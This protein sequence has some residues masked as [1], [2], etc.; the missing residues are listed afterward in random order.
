M[1]VGDMNAKVVRLGAAEASVS[2]LMGLDVGRTDNGDGFL[3]LFAGHR[4]F[5]CNRNF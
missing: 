2:G 1:L 5:L 4:M 3:Q